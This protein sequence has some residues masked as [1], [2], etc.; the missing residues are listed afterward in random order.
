MVMFI[1]SRTSDL[2]LSLGSWKVYAP[3]FPG[4]ID[5]SNFKEMETDKKFALTKMAPCTD[6]GDR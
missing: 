1:L 5:V 4:I 2:F 6:Q 3:G